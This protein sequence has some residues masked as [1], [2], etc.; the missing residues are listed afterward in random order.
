M[1]KTQKAQDKLRDILNTSLDIAIQ[2]M[3]NENFDEVVMMKSIGACKECI[4]DALDHIGK[5]KSNDLTLCNLVAIGK[6]HYVRNIEDRLN[7]LADNC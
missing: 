3:K 1:S 7:D 2:T 5:L 4:A 6:R